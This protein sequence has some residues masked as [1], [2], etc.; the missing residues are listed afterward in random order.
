MN[1]I[2]L[3]VADPF[4][5]YELTDSGDGRKLERFG[6]Y[7]VARPDPRILWKPKLPPDIW[8]RA[9]AQYTRVS[10]TDGLWD[11]RKNPPSPWT[12]RYK[13]LT[14]SLKPAQFKHVGIF[15]EQSSNWKW[16][17]ETVGSK[18]LSLLNLFGYTGA[19]TLAAVA[20]GSRVTHVDSSKPAVT[21]AHENLNLSGLPEDKTR[22]IVDDAIK[23]IKREIKRGR[24]YDGIIM[25]PPRFGRG[26]KGEVWKL[27][28]DLPALLSDIRKILSPDPLL[29]LIN[30]YTADVSA[31]TIA[32]AACD[33][34]PDPRT[35]EYGEL[36][37]RETGPG[38]R[39]VP[40]GIFVRW[41]G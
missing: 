14:F 24:T 11:I 32:N 12:I 19:A 37:I 17:T 7:T 16:I 31:V 3:V 13:N 33:L 34:V 5:D 15:P 26:A 41:K 25:D 1:D 40:H 6:T 23:F 36:A 10:K 22:W 28:T 21:W 9:D 27:E 39:L 4:P 35:L 38:A 18:N 2:G 29:L 20:A 30:V 8:N